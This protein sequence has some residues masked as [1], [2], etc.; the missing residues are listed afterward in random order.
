MRRTLQGK[1]ILVTGA[2]QGIGR[3]F[4]I[5][6]ARRGAKVVAS[7]RSAGALESLRSDAIVTVVGDVTDPAA[8]EAMV[9]TAVERFGGLDILVN[10]AGR[11]ATGLFGDTKPDT[12]RA[13]MEVNFFAL[14]ELTRLCIPALQA[15]VQPLIVNVS[16]I[17]GRRGF[18]RY[19]EYCASKF[20]VQGLSDALRAELTKVGI[21]VLVVNPGPTETGFQENMIERDG[22][23]PRAPKRMSSEAVA[24]AMLRAIERD[25]AEITLTAIGKALVLANRFAPWAVEWYFRR[26]IRREFAGRAI[27]SR[28]G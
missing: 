27:D 11:G 20:A 21:G 15:G 19:S 17:F 9:R 5:E 7:A 3:A 23:T 26:A 16:S 10:N 12:L 28:I 24:A 1:R 22:R 13:V 14:A 4:A 18:P 2:S 25:R 6:A 8:R